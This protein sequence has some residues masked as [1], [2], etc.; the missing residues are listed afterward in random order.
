MFTSSS[1]IKK[2]FA[3]KPLF[4]LIYLSVCDSLL[5]PTTHSANFTNSIFWTIKAPIT[6]LLQW[7]LYFKWACTLTSEHQSHFNFLTHRHRLILTW[8]FMLSCAVS[9]PLL[10]LHHYPKTELAD[11]PNVILDIYRYLLTINV[12]LS[13]LIFRYV[14]YWQL[15]LTS[16]YFNI[17]HRCDSQ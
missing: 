7:L 17:A 15:L 5:Q 4:H 1:E 16:W 14:Q 8:L 6:Q 3:N 9:V 10:P 13:V 2:L 11:F 12:A